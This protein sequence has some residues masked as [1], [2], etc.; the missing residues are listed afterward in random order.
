MRFCWR[1]DAWWK[2]VAAP[3]RSLKFAL[4]MQHL[5]FV[6]WHI[7]NRHVPAQVLSNALRIRRDHVLADWRGSWPRRGGDRSAFHARGRRISERAFACSRA[8]LTRARSLAGLRE[9]AGPA[10]ARSLVNEDAETGCLEATSLCRLMTW[11]SPAYPV[12]AFSYSSAIEWAVE[13]GD[14]NDAETLRRWLEVMLRAGAG[15][16]DGIFFSHAY[17]AVT[18]A[19]DG[20]LVEVAE[21]A[22]AFV[23]TRER[24]HE[25]TAMGRAF[26]EVTQAAWPCAAFVNAAAALD[27]ASRLSDRSRHGLCRSR[28]AARAASHAF[29]A[30][31]SS[32]WVSAGI[33][34]IPLGH[35][36]GQRICEG[37]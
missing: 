23:P 32:N 17:R 7:G 11:L 15:M 10:R 29:L 18:G 3:E 36:D 12:G 35:T 14:I 26:L 8:C 25:T 2:I 5:A 19:D 16:S 34:L 37:A 9:N 27:R 4:L 1:T 6:A 24:F 30:A 20:A 28:R 13:A 31:V 22:A 21:L 33:R